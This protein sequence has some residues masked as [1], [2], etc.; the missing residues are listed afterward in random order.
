[1][2]DKKA[3]KKPGILLRYKNKILTFGICFAITGVCLSLLIQHYRKG[4]SSEDLIGSMEN[5]L[6]DMRFKFRG[7]LPPTG[8]VGILAIDEKTLTKFGRWPI[9]RKNYEHLFTNLKKIGA[10]YVGF[11]VVWAEPER[12]LLEDVAANVERLASM[13][14]SADWGELGAPEI[15]EIKSVL[16]A[17]RGDQSLARA[18]KDYEKIVLGY[19]YYG[20]K[21]EGDMLG[22]QKFHGVKKMASSEIAATI[23]PD[24]SD[25][26][27]YSQF[28]T[29][30]IAGNIDHIADHAPHFAFFN[31]E[32]SNDAIFRWVQ[33]VRTVDGKLMPALSLKLAAMATGREPVV[34]F[35]KFGVTEVALMNP[36]NDQDLLKIPVDLHGNGRMLLNHLGGRMSLPHYS[37][38]DIWDDTLTDKQR[39]ELKGMTLLLGPTAVGI[40]DLR[41]NPFDAG[42]DGVEQHATVVDNILGGAFMR[43]TEQIYTVEIAVII[44]IGLL[45][46]PLMV[47]G[48]AAV[49]GI[50]ALAFLAGYY[51][52]DKY[53][54]F[55]KGE[56]VYIGLPATQITSL[57]IGTTL[58]KY[59]TEERE[60]KRTK[61]VLSLYLSPE[62]TNQVLS[63]GASLSLGGEKK[64]LTVFFS[65]VRS[66]TTISEGLTPEK[67]CELMNDYFTPMADIIQQSKGVLDKYIGDA[68][69]AFWGAPIAVP[70]HADVAADAAIKMMYALDKLRVDMPKKG[71]PMID[72]GIGLNTGFMSVGNMGSPQRFCYTVMGDSV[73]LGARLEGLTKEY[74]VKIMIS[75]FTQRKLTRPDMFTRDLD[76]IRVKGKLE[77]VKVFE[78]IRPDILRNANDIQNLVGEFHKGRDCYRKQD[79]TGAK[80]AFMACLTIRPDDG[81][82]SLYL[83]RI[84]EREAMAPIADWDGVYTFTHK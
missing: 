22:D 58:Y 77:P 67:L 17:S 38:A 83:E 9:A 74:G 37:V 51:Y 14:P 66:F 80:K 13:P 36:E 60:R 24:G 33:L 61:G 59:V 35:D 41:A 21:A 29:Y 32:L 42:F 62:V 15:A 47:F 11:D 8:K 55:A 78:L 53:F 64:E 48:R 52:F 56:W 49:S 70:N 12:P 16:S 23:F 3:D 27:S 40:N 4:G 19:I 81:P 79:W 7:T 18:L 28:N 65:D 6:L 63:E 45:F 39:E 57:F 84:E 82:A 50:G 25:L 20:T 76:D 46:A 54:W 10:G 30:G 68:I 43:R 75:E 69:M 44:G 26:S 72:I 71:F 31:N 2:A 73:N 5:R 1:M 34:F